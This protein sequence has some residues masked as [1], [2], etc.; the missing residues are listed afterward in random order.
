MN[1]PHRMELIHLLNGL[2]EV[3]DRIGRLTTL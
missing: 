2:N 1:I 3:T